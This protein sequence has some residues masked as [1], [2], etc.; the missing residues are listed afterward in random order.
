[1]TKIIDTPI[2]FFSKNYL[3]KNCE[4]EFADDKEFDFTL[5]CDFNPYKEDNAIFESTTLSFTAWFKDEYGE[6]I[7]RKINHI[8]IQNCNLKNF[9][10][11]TIINDVEITLATI[12]DNTNSELVIAIDN[13]VDLSRLIFNITALFDSETS[14]K[15]GQIRPC[16]YLFE[17]Q[18]TTETT[19]QPV[20]DEGNLRTFDG[21]LSSWVNFEK[22]GAKIQINNA[23][24]PQID[25]LKNT[26]KTD[27]Y[28]TIMPWITWEPKDIYEV[29]IAR[30]NI[31]TYAVNRWSGLI[32]TT[33]NVEAKE[34]ASN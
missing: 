30:E 8:I 32:T 19:V 11:K 27:G 16:Q 31:G 3:N 7:S 9:T 23:R 1:M 26:L 12:T 10:I 13:D 24:K 2:K 15:I 25:L 28:V 14:V 18:A 4:F 29:M 17:L 21:S 33:I 6:Y 34:N 5:L 20:V 22:W